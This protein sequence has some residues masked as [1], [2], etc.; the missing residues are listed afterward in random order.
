M[1]LDGPSR[2]QI[3]RSKRSEL[4]TLCEHHN[5]SLEGN[6]TTL[7]HRL[8]I[9]VF[10]SEDQSDTPPVVSASSLENEDVCDNQNQRTT[11]SRGVESPGT[12]CASANE[13]RY[14]SQSDS[15]VPSDLGAATDAEDLEVQNKSLFR[16]LEPTVP[17]AS[18]TSHQIQKAV[19]RMTPEMKDNVV[20]KYLRSSQRELFKELLRRAV[21]S[22]LKINSSPASLSDGQQIPK[23]SIKQK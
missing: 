10:G 1:D 21:V 13:G 11:E 6:V 7:R 5:L 3:A 4:I 20:I 9:H 16:L 23:Q 22:T 19:F 18:D 14:E 17:L 2:T 8:L 15:V 12:G